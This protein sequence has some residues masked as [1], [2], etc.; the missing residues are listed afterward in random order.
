MTTQA[1]KKRIEPCRFTARG[2][3]CGKCLTCLIRKRSSLTARG[4]MEAQGLPPD[5]TQFLTLTYNEDFLPTVKGWDNVLGVEVEHETLRKRDLQNFLR[6]LNGLHQRRTGRKIRSLNA[7]EYG[8]LGSRPH[9]HLILFGISSELA[10][11]LCYLAW[12]VPKRPGLKSEHVSTVKVK[13]P[14]THPSCYHHVEV[15]AA[16]TRHQMG[17][18]TFGETN[19]RTVAYTASYTLSALAQG[20][21][22]PEGVEPEFA[23]WSTHPGLGAEFIETYGK[24]LAEHYS[25]V[26]LPSTYGPDKPFVGLP[27]S[28][29][30]PTDKGLR[31]FAL[32]R[33]MRQ[34]MLKG[35][36]VE[37][38]SEEAKE[39]RKYAF[40]TRQA[41]QELPGDP[42]GLA[43]EHREM[44]RK[45]V[46]RG[47][48]MVRRHR[49][50][51]KASSPTP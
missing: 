20:K 22:R 10:Y 18:L 32:D 31:P 23:T 49:E 12:S 24:H 48:R 15:D 13:T 30:L 41:A 44:A 39:A 17:F 6:R 43:S 28:I 4:V 38:D 19:P 16:R 21:E 29:E 37:W 45:A 3:A 36:G 51:R 5:Q 8:S 40:E 14:N 34:R 35:I 26:G 1:N 2:Y 27:N 25:I 50:R 7:G 33:T 47:E 42:L 9:Y 46:V 11:E